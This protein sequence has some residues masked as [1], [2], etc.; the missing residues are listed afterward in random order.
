M[1]SR[2]IAAQRGT[3]L[4]INLPGSLK[5]A[6]ENWAGIEDVLPHAVSMMAGGGHK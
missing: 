4:I 3:V 1:L 6:R 2:A 5:A